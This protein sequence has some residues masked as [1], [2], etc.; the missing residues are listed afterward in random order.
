MYPKIPQLKFFNVAKHIITNKA[1][2]QNMHTQVEYCYNNFS[3]KQNQQIT[4]NNT[5]NS[6]TMLLTLI[7]N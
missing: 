1:I 5:Q 7:N 6:T 2:V 4:I 3:K